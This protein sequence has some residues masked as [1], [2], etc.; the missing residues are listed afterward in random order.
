MTAAPLSYCLN[1]LPSLGGIIGVYCHH[2]Y[3]HTN[4]VP[5][6]LLKGSD[7][8][9]ATIFKRL[10][11]E[12]GVQPILDDHAGLV[13]R[14]K[15]DREFQ[16]LQTFQRH[17]FGDNDLSL[18]YDDRFY[19]R[20]PPPT[21][22]EERLKNILKWRKIEGMTG[23]EMGRAPGTRS[24]CVGDALGPVVIVEGAEQQEVTRSPPSY[25]P[26]EFMM[27]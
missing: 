10:K 8:I 5:R 15:G 13:D 27:T 23:Q 18:E 14:L 3:G 11:I 25:I 4:S 7:L 1:F 20:F 24:T 19:C 6:Y 16:K 21:S 2:Q 12:T 17:G 22:F 26:T 9:L